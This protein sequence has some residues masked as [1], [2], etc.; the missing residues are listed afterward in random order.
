MAAVPAPSAAAPA[1]G[2]NTAGT[3]LLLFDTATPGTMTP[4]PI[5]GLGPGETIAGIDRRPATGALYGLG[6]VDG[7]AT[8]A[9]RLYRIDPATGAATPIAPAP[10][11]AQTGGTDYGVDFT[12]LVDRLRVINDGNENLRLNPN[13]GG[14][15]G[16]DPNLTDLGPDV[17][18]RPIEGIAYSSNV[19]PPF[20]VGGGV[21][22]TTEFGI[23]PFT[24]ELVTIGGF[25]GGAPGGQNGGLVGDEKP[26]GFNAG[27]NVNFDI[28]DFSSVGFLTSGISFG[29]VNLGTGT[30]TF[31]GNLAQALDGFAVLPATTVT[32][33]PRAVTTSEAAGVATIT[34]TRSSTASPA[35]V[36]VTTEQANLGVPETDTAVSGDDFQPLDTR[37]N[38]VG[39]QAEATVTVPIVADG[40]GEGEEAFTVFLAD[41]GT[42]TGLGVNTALGADRAT[43]TIAADPGPPPPPPPPPPPALDTTGPFAVLI[44]AASSLKRSALAAHGLAVRYV[45]G[46][47]CG[48]TFTLKLSKR[49]LGTAKARL[50]KAGLGSVRL[51]LTRAGKRALVAALKEHRSVRA[52]LSATLTDAAGN[53]T[54][55]TSRI[56]I[57][58]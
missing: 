40:I 31:T 9:L 44:P 21:G 13:S 47:A 52:T 43:V 29:T 55:K 17:D 49:T 39:D 6:V 5:T 41:P 16:D 53:P 58:R 28:A 23:A 36:R 30:F 50:T 2:V 3:S 7:G 46:E 18:S 27:N 4:V 42:N 57:K 45:C 12:P 25:A 14:L 34:L 38:F 51:R 35:S 33:D 10:V 1:V 37:V 22:S 48:A 20:G 26:L 54:A 15:A 56:T 24:D 32:L 11:T 8:D 19:A